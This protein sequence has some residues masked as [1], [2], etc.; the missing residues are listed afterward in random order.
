MGRKKVLTPDQEMR[1]QQ[2]AAFLEEVEDFIQVARNQFQY[3]DTRSILQLYQAYILR[4]KIQQEKSLENILRNILRN[5]SGNP[6][7][8]IQRINL[9]EILGKLPAEKW[10]PEELD[11][12]EEVDQIQEK[13]LGTMQQDLS[14]ESSREYVET[15]KEEFLLHTSDLGSTLQGVELSQADIDLLYLSGPDIVDDEEE[16]DEIEEVDPA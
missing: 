8:N 15:L 2:A 16:I 13:T 6:S 3:Y 11:P 14:E 4:Q 7:E 9:K 1:R 12:E 5:I 10:S